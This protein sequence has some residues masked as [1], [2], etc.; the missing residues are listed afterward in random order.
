MKFMSR[1]GSEMS[2]EIYEDRPRSGRPAEIVSEELKKCFLQYLSSRRYHA[3]VRGIASWLRKTRSTGCTDSAL[4]LLNSVGCRAMFVCVCVKPKL[5][6]KHILNRFLYC[7][8]RLNEVLNVRTTNES[9]DE[10]DIFVDEKWFNK[11]TT[12]GYMWLK[13]NIRME[14]AVDFLRHKSYI[15]TIMYFAAIS[16]LQ[17]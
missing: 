16:M 10:V 7:C 13:E 14:Q 4:E 8:E 5:E 2:I 3:T 12:G 15:H 11:V 1:D 9:T 17:K 6:R